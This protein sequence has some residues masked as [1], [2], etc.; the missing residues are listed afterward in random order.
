MNVEL[1]KEQLIKIQSNVS[2]LCC[3]KT[4]VLLI[5][6]LLHPFP[7]H[8]HYHCEEILNKFAKEI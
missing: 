7:H 5:C 3:L 4:F 8:C 1:S 2:F 6:I